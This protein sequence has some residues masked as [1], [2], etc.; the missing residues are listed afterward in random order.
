VCATIHFTSGRLT[1]RDQRAYVICLVAIAIALIGC[2]EPAE[3]AP[4]TTASYGTA[5][6]IEGDEGVVRTIDH[7]VPLVSMVPANAGQ[8]V[9]L[10]VRERIRANGPV[11]K[12]VLMVHGRSIP[13]VPGLAFDD[14]RYDWSGALARAGFDV[15]VLDLQGSGRSPLPDRSILRFDPV[16][17]EM[18]GVLDDPCNLLAADL[19]LVPHAPCAPSYP[20]QLVTAASEWHELDVVVDYIRALRGVDKVALI[21]WSH[22]ASRVG[23]Y[24]VQHSDKV[25]SLLLH[26]PFY[27]PAMP[28]GRQGTGPDQIGPPIDVRTGAPFVLPQP[29]RPMQPLVTKAA[30]LEAW[31]REIGCENQVEEGMQDAAWNAIMADETVGRTWAPPDGAIRVRGFFLWGWNPAMVS[32]ISVPTLIIAGELDR[33][34]PPTF[35]RL[36]DELTGVPDNKLMVTIQCAGHSM[37]WERQSKVLHHISKQWLKHGTVDDHTSGRFFVDTEGVIRP[38]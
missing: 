13:A 20:F 11:R 17:N 33:S 2:R 34:V 36:Y 16:R 10:F 27:D 19:P 18:V 4:F 12:A 35:D 7:A 38:R 9:Q 1:V 23:P 37:V 28:A 3:P 14:D 29:G 22:G 5:A 32:R 6:D 30:F 21:G 8:A 15:F 31:N 25:E 26:T 24:A